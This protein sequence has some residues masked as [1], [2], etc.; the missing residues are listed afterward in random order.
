MQCEQQNGNRASI[1]IKYRN[2]L[3]EIF[4][5]GNEPGVSTISRFHRGVTKHR[6]RGYNTTYKCDGKGDNRLIKVR[7]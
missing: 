3:I 4:E 7:V 1:S 6:V 5:T 2:G